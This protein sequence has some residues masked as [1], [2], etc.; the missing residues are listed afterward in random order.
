MTCKLCNATAFWFANAA[1]RDYYRCDTCRS[2]MLHPRFLLSPDEEKAR[3]ETH[4]NCPR[5]PRY[6]KFV[7]PIVDA[8][9]ERF[10]KQARG[11]DF[12]AGTGPVITKMLTDAGYSMALYDPFFHDN[13]NALNQRYDFIACCEVIEHFHQPAKEFRLLRS[14]LKKG[15]MLYCKTELFSENTDFEAWYYKNDP[16]HVFFYNEKSFAWICEN[17]SFSYAHIDGRL[18]VLKA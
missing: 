13:P 9:K 7:S 18:I 3:Y 14:L 4:N 2:V 12:G 1:S 11:L 8:V 15:G 16:T 6:Q 5:D 17:L 10:G